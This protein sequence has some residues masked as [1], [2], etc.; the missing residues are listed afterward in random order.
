VHWK[1]ESSNPTLNLQ[2]KFGFR[3]HQGKLVVLRGEA[4]VESSG[5]NSDMVRFAMAMMKQILPQN[6]M[7]E[8][9]FRFFVDLS[10][11]LYWD[12]SPSFQ[13]QDGGSL[14]S[15][16]WNNLSAAVQFL[17]RFEGNSLVELGLFKTKL[18]PSFES[19]D[20]MLLSLSGAVE[21]LDISLEELSISSKYRQGKTVSG[22]EYFDLTL[23]SVLKEGRVRYSEQAL[24]NSKDMSF[25][26]NARGVDH[27]S[28]FS[29]LKSI[30]GA[31][32]LPRTR[33]SLSVYLAKILAVLDKA[34]L[35]L[36]FEATSDKLRVS[37]K[38][39]DESKVDNEKSASFQVDCLNVANEDLLVLEHLTFKTDPSDGI[40]GLLETLTG[41]AL[42]QPADIWIEKNKGQ[43]YLVRLGEDMN[44]TKL[45]QL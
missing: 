34:D 6:I 17:S 16:K 23:E 25:N 29:Q 13:S 9:G 37:I 27:V 19:N 36:N 11:T 14:V 3:W 44:V 5:A 41:E 45:E 24:L 8:R 20:P 40:C 39:T 35:T 30:L 33:L 28:F 2:I 15:V 43:R 31:V 7:S 42:A 4:A 38:N 22:K 21:N 26:L 1:D 10:R 18:D 32:P 12:V